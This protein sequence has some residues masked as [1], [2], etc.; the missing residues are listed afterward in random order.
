MKFHIV[1]IDKCYNFKIRF[2]KMCYSSVDR[3]IR[4]NLF[5]IQYHHVGAIYIG[6]CCLTAL[7]SSITMATFRYEYSIAQ[8]NPLVLQ[9]DEF[10]ALK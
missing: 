10:D 9:V 4:S 5:E 1:V 7:N 3:F 2:D 6:V 8:P